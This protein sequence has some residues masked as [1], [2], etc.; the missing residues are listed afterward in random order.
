MSRSRAPLSD[1]SPREYNIYPK[2]YTPRPFEPECGRFLTY[3]VN[4][5]VNQRK[6]DFY[7][8]KSSAAHHIMTSTMEFCIYKPCA[9]TCMAS[10]SRRLE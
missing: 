3:S 9:L 1:L 6:S 4:H 2:M 7:L 5:H 8:D 10:S